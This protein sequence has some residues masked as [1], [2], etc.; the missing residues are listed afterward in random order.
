MPRATS[1]AAPD[2]DGN[3]VIGQYDPACGSDTPGDPN[4]CTEATATYRNDTGDTNVS[5][6]VAEPVIIAETW[7][8]TVDLTGTTN[9]I[10]SVVG[11]G[12]AGET[13]WALADDYI[14]VDL[15]AA[16]GEVLGLPLQAGSGVLTFSRDIPCD[17][18]LP[19]Y[20][21]A[22]Q[23]YSVGGADGITLHNA[24]DLVVGTY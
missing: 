15:S 11:F 18:V 4:E 1:G 2:G 19:G 5:G 6:F 21:C 24:Y 22:T 14:L 17:C 23:G 8:C 3:W 16:P 13:Y 7:T 12:G 20:F 9:T 10:A